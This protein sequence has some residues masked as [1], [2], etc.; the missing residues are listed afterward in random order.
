VSAKKVSFLRIQRKRCFFSKCF[1]N[2]SVKTCWW[3][4]F[5]S[6]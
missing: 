2:R 1:S 4:F 5:C 3:S 6:A